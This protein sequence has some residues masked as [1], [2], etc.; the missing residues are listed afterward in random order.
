[1]KRVLIL[2]VGAAL[3]ACGQS[4]VTAEKTAAEGDEQTPAVIDALAITLDAQP[5]ELKARYP[6]RHPKETL[7]FMGIEPGMTVV[8]G[9]PGSGWYT[10]ILL[11]YLGSDGH[12]IPR[13]VRLRNGPNRPRLLC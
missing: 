13:D 8:E 12:L 1:M 5:D 9:L 11:P 2:L 3:A 4:Q 10:R 6:Y 7:E